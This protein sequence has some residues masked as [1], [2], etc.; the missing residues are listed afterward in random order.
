MSFSNLDD[1]DLL[2]MITYKVLETD[3]IVFYSLLVEVK[4]R[5]IDISALINDNNNYH[6]WY[7]TLPHCVVYFT[8]KRINMEKNGDDFTGGKTVIPQRLGLKIFNLLLD[9]GANLNIE[10]YYMITVYDYR[11]YEDY[12]YTLNGR[13]NNERL[14]ERINELYNNHNEEINP[15]IKF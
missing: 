13:T 15:R 2:S 5:D 7:S 10:N 8:G 4:N 11:N 3:P 9:L 1:D 14:V 6:N 12:E